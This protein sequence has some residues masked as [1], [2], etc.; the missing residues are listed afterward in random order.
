[1]SYSGDSFINFELFDPVIP[2]GAKWGI[3]ITRASGSNN[4]VAVG[5][6]DGYFFKTTENGQFSMVDELDIGVTTT[7]DEFNDSFKYDAQAN[8][9]PTQRAIVNMLDSKYKTENYTIQYVSSP[10]IE[11]STLTGTE[12]PYFIRVNEL[13]NG[14][15]V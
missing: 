5:R 8:K 2:V 11:S 4:Q 1:M 9:V 3:R 15:T 7:I 13:T 14:I 12:T 10:I 6:F